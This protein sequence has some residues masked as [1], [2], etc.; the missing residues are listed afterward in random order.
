MADLDVLI[1][2]GGPAGAV[3]ALTLARRGWTV[4]VLDRGAGGVSRPGEFLP[5]AARPILERLRLYGAFEQAEHGRAHGVLSA[6]GEPT[7]RTHDFLFDP[8]GYGWR[9]DRTRFDGL[10]LDAAA[11]DGAQVQHGALVGAVQRV[12]A[13]W[14]VTGACEGQAFA[15]GA[16]FII[17][18]RGRSGAAWLPCKRSLLDSMAAAVISVGARNQPSNDKTFALVESCPNGWWY[19]VYAPDER[20]LVTFL[21]EAESFRGGRNVLEQTLRDALRTAPHTLKRT[22]GLRWQD[23]PRVVSART[24][25][26]FQPGDIPCLA[27]G[28]ASFS[29][30]PLSSLGLTHAL[31]SGEAAGAAI[32]SA[33]CGSLD[34]LEDYRRR[35]LHSF[36]RYI[37]AR[38]VEYARER[39]W[40]DSK[41]WFRRTVSDF[42]PTMTPSQ[43]RLTEEQLA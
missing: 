37:D 14:W 30:D 40:P 36:R 10:I 28:D 6:W 38:H 7:L 1:V 9:L 32:H 33:L 5:P 42:P 29:V 16:R 24:T 22:S 41:F 15:L 34:A 13:G 11:E 12:P 35:E 27:V 19:S 31:A 8:Y 26:S 18:A 39:R 25:L 4:T 20:L 2:G 23:P 17:D 3:A 21:S 43:P